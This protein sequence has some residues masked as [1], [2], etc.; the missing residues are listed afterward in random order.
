[1][2]R[3]SNTISLGDAIK[4][5][6]ANYKHSGKLSEAEAVQAWPKVMGPNIAAYTQSV[7]IKNGKLYVQLK[8]SALRAELLMHRAKIVNGLNQY[9]KSDVVKD[10]V[11]R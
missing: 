4:E 3:K 7:Y 10:L 8:S 1:M 5:F 9:L 2:V 6:L 11:L